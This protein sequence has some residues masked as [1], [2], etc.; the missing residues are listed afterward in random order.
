[1]RVVKSIH[2]PMMSRTLLGWLCISGLRKS[3]VISMTEMAE[4]VFVS[5]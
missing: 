2:A 3:A 5:S 1:M 4:L